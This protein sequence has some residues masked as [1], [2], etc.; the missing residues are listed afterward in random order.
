MSED[1]VRAIVPAVV[2]E[3]DR[4]KAEIGRLTADNERANRAYDLL[5][6]HAKAC[7]AEIDVLRAIIAGAIGAIEAGS[8]GAPLLEVLRGEITKVEGK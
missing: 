4:L 1:L 2:A 6:E 7:D 8:T 5:E 3:T